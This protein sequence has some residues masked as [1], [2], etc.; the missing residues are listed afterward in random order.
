[1]ILALGTIAIA[2]L[3]SSAIETGILDSQAHSSVHVF[4]CVRPSPRNSRILPGP[5][6]TRFIY[7]GAEYA[8]GE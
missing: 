6:V 7:L 1:V 8:N 3:S 2:R 4:L 5:A